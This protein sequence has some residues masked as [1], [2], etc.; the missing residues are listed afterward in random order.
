MFLWLNS[1]GSTDTFDVLKRA[2]L[3]FWVGCWNVQ[4]IHLMYW[5]F[6]IHASFVSDE[7][8][9]RYIW[10]IETVL[11]FKR[12]L[13]L[14]LFN[15]YIWCIETIRESNVLKRNLE[16]NRYIWC[17]ETLVEEKYFGFNIRFNR[18]IWCI[19]TLFGRE[20][21]GRL[22]RSTDT[23]DVLKP[24]RKLSNYLIILFNRY[25]WCIET[26]QEFLYSPLFYLFN[27]YI[28]CI[29]TRLIAL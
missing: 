27:R 8:F 6:F 21:T 19:E 10:C 13:C 20:A 25:I 22:T 9:N 29:E 14:C 1:L 24:V 5:N 26:F 11:F 16:F 12:R 3:C 18:Y 7:R 17:I 2:C 28:W 15:R 4:P 23:F